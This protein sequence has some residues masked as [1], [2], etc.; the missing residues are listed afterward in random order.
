MNWK[1]QIVYQIFVDRFKRGPNFSKKVSDGLY[2]RD[3]GQVKKWSERPSRHSKGMEFFGGD[4]EGIIEKMDYI[5]SLGVNVLYLT[6]IFLAKTNHKYDTHDFIV[7]PQFGDDKILKELISRAHEKNIAVI[8]DGVFN[9]VGADGKWF[10][11]SKK[12]GVGGAYNDEKSKYKDFF[13]F[14]EWPNKYGSWHDAKI[15]AELNLKNEDLRRILFSDENSVIKRYLKMGID[16][17]R[18]DCAHDLGHEINSLIF[19]SAKSVNP[20]A[21]VVGEVSTYPQAWL[22]EGELDGVMNYYFANVVLGGLNGTYSPFIVKKELD[23]MVKEIGV[24]KLSNSWNMLSSHDTPRLKRLVKDEE[25][26]K[27]AITLQISYPGNPLIYYGEENG[28]DGGEDPDNRR[29]MIWEEEKWD[30]KFRKFVIRALKIK[31]QEPALSGGKYLELSIPPSSTLMGFARY[32]DNPDDTLFVFANFSSQSV[33]EEI[34][35]PF[36]YFLSH[37]PSLFLLGKGEAYAKT[38]SLQ[39]KLPPKMAVILKLTPAFSNYKMYK[40]LYE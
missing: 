3:G 31:A 16:G 18:L 2:T 32:T 30:E 22:K 35:I 39:V 37:S 38:S 12:Y 23:R 27:M 40:Y 25:F 19:K 7:D 9:H 24:D 14:E 21:Y 1:R 8:L 11:R 15:L 36:S 34:P 10:N 33:E 5:S 28:M 4:L 20:N 17:W 29:P 26:R 13:H 6:P